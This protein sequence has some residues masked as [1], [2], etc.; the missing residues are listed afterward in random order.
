[1]DNPTLKNMRNHRTVR[2]FSD[3]ALSTSDIREAVEAAQCA[4]TSSWIQAYSILQVTDEAERQT[5]AELSG[6]Q[7]QVR[8]APG[9]FVIC[10]DSRRHR[11][12][13]EKEGKPF[14]NNFEVFLTTVIDASLFAQNLV[15][16]FESQ[17]HGTCL[18]GGLRTRLADVAKLLEFPEG[19]YPLYGLCVGKPAEDPGTRPRL[20][21]EAVCFQGRYPSDEAMRIQMQQADQASE[22]YYTKRG[23]PARTWSRGMLRRFAKLNREDLPQAYLNLGAELS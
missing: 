5:L 6:G 8:A 13:M 9:F 2:S 14:Q 3:E 21:F 1:M 22:T 12:L 19:V 11:L 15:L 18:I 16:A 20:P 17:G 10:G 23:A 7:T 4:A